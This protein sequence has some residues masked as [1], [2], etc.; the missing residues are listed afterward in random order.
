M[1]SIKKR[2]YQKPRIDY[3]IL[4]KGGK[5]TKSKSGQRAKDKQRLRRFGDV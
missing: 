3:P 1:A 5:H 2:F 4:K